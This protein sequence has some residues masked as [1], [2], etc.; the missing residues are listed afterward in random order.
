[1][2]DNTVQIDNKID[3]NEEIVVNLF[4][5]ARRVFKELRRSALIILLLMAL[6][7]TACY[8]GARA[9][10]KPVYAA[11]ATFSIDRVS[12]LRYR[13]GGDKY[14][15]IN[16]MGT[17]F[18]FFLSSDA[19]KSAVMDDLEFHDAEDFDVEIAASAGFATN[20][21][22]LVVR[23]KD[24][25][26]AYDALQSVL[27][28]FPTIT[29][30]S[31]GE[32]DFKLINMGG[33]PTSP[34]VRPTNKKTA[35]IG[36]IFVLAVALIWTIFKCVFIKNIVNGEALS[37]VLDT[38]LLGTLPYVKCPRGKKPAAIDSVDCPP[39]MADAVHTIRLRLERI[40]G[41]RE[42]KT[43]LV[44]STLSSEG[45]TTTAANLAISL[46]SHQHKVLLAEGNLRNPS[47]LAALGMPQA[48]KG[49]ADLLTGS[50]EADEVMIPYSNDANLTV[51]PGGT[52][53][54]LP[55]ALWS[56]PEAEKL[57]KEWRER[58]DYII[59]DSASAASCSESGLIA[60]LADGCIYVGQEDRELA[61]DVRR[62][63]ETVTSAGCG[64][65]GCV[66]NAGH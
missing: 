43:I 64:I 13:S 16:K 15:I 35:V 10:Y 40:A 60:R 42:A 62:G 28:K 19:M 8:F 7:G 46:A 20:L 44:T 41:E 65:L 39:Q 45:K 4:V 61:D 53:N 25:Q 24:P 50:C 3:N 48:E 9:S 22:G 2:Q 32:V 55:A 66:Y 34:S 31:I 47:V 17:W 58:F 14:L 23:S 21:I 49:M 37:K 18:P 30:H 59:I 11:S 63:A 5:L 12:N 54:R 56:R 52:L 27:R 38:E 33:V 29:E 6:T 1:M 26:L 51:I 57:F 36:M